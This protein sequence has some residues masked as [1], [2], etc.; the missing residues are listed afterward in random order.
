MTYQTDLRSHPAKSSLGGAYAEI[1]GLGAFA[2][3]AMALLAFGYNTRERDT[4]TARGG[5]EMSI[6][7]QQP[8]GKNFVSPMDKAAPPTS[9]NTGQGSANGDQPPARQ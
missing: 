5:G 1:F 4:R 7:A 9:S 3:V 6:Q 2:L 8:N